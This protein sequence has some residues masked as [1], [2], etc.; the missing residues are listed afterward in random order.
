MM[1]ALSAG[2]WVLF[3]S[4]LFR[5]FLNLIS[6]LFAFL[7]SL[8]NFQ[9][10]F[11]F[12]L[13]CNKLILCFP[14]YNFPKNEK[15]FAYLPLIEHKIDINMHER[16]TWHYQNG[17]KTRLAWITMPCIKK[18]CDHSFT[19]ALIL[20][21]TSILL[22]TVLTISTYTIDFKSVCDN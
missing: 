9:H 6:P 16:R 8:V 21:G 20:Y 3:R 19:I 4:L 22:S 18:I 1:T 11:S 10:K 14:P 17:T 12:R 13:W 5:L 15:I 7:K 2:F